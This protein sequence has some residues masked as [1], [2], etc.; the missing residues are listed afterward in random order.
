MTRSNLAFLLLL[1]A[2]G[3]AA[4]G[5]A[6]ADQG[7]FV[8]LQEEMETVKKDVAAARASAAAARRS[9]SM[10]TEMKNKLLKRSRKGRMSATTW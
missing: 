3:V 2:L 8:R 7:A 1:G 6:I 5:C 4:G 10:P 9:M